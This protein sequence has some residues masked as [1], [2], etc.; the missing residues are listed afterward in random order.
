MV[1]QWCK[2][3]IFV[4][5]PIRQSSISQFEPFIV[6]YNY[7]CV[8]F[9]TTQRKNLGSF[10][11]PKSILGCLDTRWTL[12]TLHHWGGLFLK[13]FCEGAQGSKNNLFLMYELWC[14]SRK[15]VNEK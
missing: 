8:V 11:C 15:V 12:M 10:G 6:I 3:R 4:S 1:V 7:K 5:C 9:R 13:Y 14:M 2:V